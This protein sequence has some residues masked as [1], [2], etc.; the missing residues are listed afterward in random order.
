MN[1]LYQLVRKYPLSVLLF[2]VIWYLSFFTPPQTELDNVEFIDKWVH[3][4]MYGGTCTVLWIE[5]LRRHRRLDAVKLLLFAWLA[6]ILM[7]GLIEILQENCTDGRRSGDWLDFAANATGVT[8]A[9]AIG[10]GLWKAKV[11]RR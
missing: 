1:C 9:A 8:L 2:L 4:T 7:S 10:L 3:V 11:F 6:P 5:Y